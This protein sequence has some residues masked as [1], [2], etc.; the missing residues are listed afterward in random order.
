M[1]DS[2][3]VIGQRKLLSEE[4]YWRQWPV[5]LVSWLV[6]WNGGPEIQGSTITF[7]KDRAIYL[8]S[9]R[10]WF[11]MHL[12]IDPAVLPEET[13]E[14]GD[15]Q[16]QFPLSDQT[17]IYHRGDA[18]TVKPCAQIMAEQKGVEAL[19]AQVDRIREKLKAHAVAL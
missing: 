8:S 17:L 18:L 7:D 11:K 3:Y 19:T 5:R 14:F 12:P 1:T 2:G 9:K 10:G 16:D 15:N 13:V 4:P 6:G